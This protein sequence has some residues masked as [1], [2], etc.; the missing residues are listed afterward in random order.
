MGKGEEDRRI[1]KCR[2]SYFLRHAPLTHLLRRR[3]PYI[4]RCG[5]WLIFIGG[6]NSTKERYPPPLQLFITGLA[7]KRRALEV[8]R[9]NFFWNARRNMM[10]S[11]TLLTLN[12]LS[13]KTNKTHSLAP[14][15]YTLHQAK[16][17]APPL[18]EICQLAACNYSFESA[19]FV[20]VNCKLFLATCDVSIACTRLIGWTWCSLTFRNLFIFALITTELCAISNLFLGKSRQKKIA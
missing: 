20:P 1:N 8:R 14:L 3:R 4:G 9:T 11:S 12:P 18:F 10:I 17:H 15:P 7:N 2:P 19:K 6:L 5:V 16:D 13:R